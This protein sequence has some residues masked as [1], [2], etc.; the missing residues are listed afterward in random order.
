MHRITIAAFVFAFSLSAGAQP[1]RNDWPNL[2]RYR[3]ANAALPPPA[4]GEKRV[5]FIGDSITDVWTKYFDTQFAGKPY[6][7][8]GIDGQTTPQMLVR[9]RQDVI[10][11]RPAAVVIL[12]GVN[13]I[14][15]NTGPSTL[16]MIENNLMSMADLARANHIAVVLCSLLP[17]A[18]FP[19]R[20]ELAPAPQIVALNSWMKRYAAQN[21]VTF[22]DYWTAMADEENGLP[23]ALSRDGVHP[24]EAGYRVMVPLVE[25]GIRSALRSRQ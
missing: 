11:L 5:V 9:F 18:K 23:T 21:A 17:A 24:N 16:D 3:D 4:R 13:D 2:Q 12:A 7:N 20:P 1:A 15:G 19:W 8:R 6:V 10:A 14:A 22:V 25:R